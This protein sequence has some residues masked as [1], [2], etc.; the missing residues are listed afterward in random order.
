MSDEAQPGGE[1]PA[2][3]VADSAPAAAPAPEPQATEKPETPPEVDRPETEA[4]PEAP[5]PPTVRDNIKLRARA[6]DAEAEVAYWR[7]RAEAV[8]QQPQ[9]P[10]AP[11]PQ[12]APVDVSGMIGPPPDPAKFA[13]GEYDPA[14]IKAG[15]IHD[16]KADAAREHVARQQQ[17]AAARDAATERAFVDRLAA[18]EADYPEIREHALTIGRHVPAP[19]ADAFVASMATEDGGADV[20]R[21]FATNKAEL[22]RLAGLSPVQVAVEFGRIAERAAH[23]RATA[24]ATSAPPPPKIVSGR[25]PSAPNLYDPN[26]PVEEYA[27]LRGLA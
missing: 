18:A 22:S 6:R 26:L 21:H 23:A 12:A 24:P 1:I 2:P 20:V 8:Q 7:G 11:Q 10:T 16:I 14:Y 3:A 19:V 25:A 15:A 17:A 4:E 13:A 5:K 27:R 9:Q